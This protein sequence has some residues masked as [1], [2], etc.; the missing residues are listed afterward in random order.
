M[1]RGLLF[2]AASTIIFALAWQVWRPA[3][4]PTAQPPLTGLAAD[5][6]VQFQKAFNDASDRARVILLLSP[7]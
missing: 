5:N 3:R 1:K 6:L 4:T 7:T 2:L